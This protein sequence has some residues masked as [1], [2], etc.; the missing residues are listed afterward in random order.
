[1]ANDSCVSR[2]S[3]ETLPASD[4][5]ERG[6]EG[7]QLISFTAETFNTPRRSYEDTA[8]IRGVMRASISVATDPASN[9]T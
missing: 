1:M 6:R 9:S 3:Y 8:E 5:V 2:L 4:I 7:T